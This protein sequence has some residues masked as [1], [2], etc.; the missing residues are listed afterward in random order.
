M[1]STAFLAPLA[2]T[3]LVRRAADAVMVR[4]AHHRAV[5]LDHTDVPRTQHNTLMKLVR[6]ARNTRFGRDH[7]FSRISSV[8][9]YQARVKVREYE[10]FWNTYWKDSY[11]RIDNIT[12]PGWIPYYALSSGTTSGATKY[13]P[14]SRE[15]V[16]SN[17]KAAFTTTGLFRHSYPAAKLLTGKFFFLGGTTEL[18]KQA[19]G[20]LAGDLSGIAATEV[21]EVMRP[22]TFPPYDLALIANWE[23]KLT[24]FAELSVREPITAISGVPS[25]MQRLFHRVKQLT[26][27]STVAEVWPQLRMV[28]HGG[29]KFEPFRD[30]FIKEIGSDAVKFCE[31]YPCSEAFVATEDPRYNLLRIVPDHDVFFEFVPTEELD[32]RHPR[33]EFPTR[34]TLENVETGVQYA[35]VLTTCAGLWSYLVGDTIAFERRTPPLIRFTGRTKYFLSAFGEHLISEEVEQAVAK[36]CRAC[37]VYQTDFHVGPVF[38]TDPHKPG[39]HVYLVEF[40]DAVPDLGRFAKEIDDELTRLNEDYGPH[41]IG[42]QA[43]LMPQVRAIKPGGFAEWMRKVRGKEAGGQNK[44]PRMDNSGTITRGMLE[45]F[46]EHGWLSK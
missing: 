6:T 13:L 45:W 43:M 25:W 37:G 40:V 8:A 31:V 24:K 11:P 35:V 20:S 4:Y 5:E 22:Y 16:N 23:E 9:D 10:W 44:I 42:D 39:H 28:V 21:Y 30:L 15:M 18:R 38:S 2:N 17:K 3:R 46:T 27:K 36:A 29:A 34:H 12:W 41:R 7:D 19:D 32:D 1:P 33:K 14:V 26:G